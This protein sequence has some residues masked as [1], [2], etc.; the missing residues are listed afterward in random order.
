MVYLRRSGGN[1]RRRYCNCVPTVCQ[2]FKVY[3]DVRV[4]SEAYL[5]RQPFP[6]GSNSVVPAIVAASSPSRTISRAA[7]TNVR[8]PNLIIFRS[9]VIG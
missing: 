1:G 5:S 9:E 2:T 8:L 6:S 4:R 3:G 7:D